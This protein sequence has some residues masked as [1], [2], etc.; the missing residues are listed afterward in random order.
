MFG[1][2]AARHFSGKSVAVAQPISNQG[3]CERSFQ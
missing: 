1:G 2:I 3:S